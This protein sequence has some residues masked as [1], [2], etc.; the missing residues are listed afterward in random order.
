MYHSS[1]LPPPPI[2]P[3]ST[4]N[5]LTRDNFQLRRGLQQVADENIVVHHRRNIDEVRHATEVEFLNHEL[6]K[7]KIYI[8]DLQGQN[9]ELLRK[10]QIDHREIMRLRSTIDELKDHFETLIRAKDLQLNDLMQRIRTLER[11]REFG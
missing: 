1:Y 4:L 3:T 11:E 6:S 7:L 8:S 5:Y 9:Q 2:H 10:R